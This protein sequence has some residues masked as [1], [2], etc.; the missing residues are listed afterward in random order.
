MSDAQQP[1]G[2]VVVRAPEVEHGQVDLC[3]DL[4]TGRQGSQCSHHVW[5][6]VVEARVPPGKNVGGQRKQEDEGDACP[7]GWQPA[8]GD[9][10]LPDVRV[11]LAESLNGCERA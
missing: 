7:R 5:R 4:Q 10:P 9:G 6:Q 3:G 2:Q 8:S 11:L 1:P